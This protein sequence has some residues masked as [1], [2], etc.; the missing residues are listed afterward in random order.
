MKSPKKSSRKKAAAKVGAKHKAKAKTDPLSKVKAKAR[1][2]IAAKAKE[3]NIDLVYWKKRLTKSASGEPPNYDYWLKLEE[4]RER[5]ELW[6]ASCIV[7]GLDPR[8]IHRNVAGMFGVFD[9]PERQELGV[10]KVDWAGA[11][12]WMKLTIEGG[13]FPDNSIRRIIEGVYLKD[14]V[15]YR[16]AN[17]EP[18]PT[19]LHSLY[20]AP[21]KRLTYDQIFKATKALKGSQHE[22]STK[23]NQNLE[24]ILEPY[25]QKVLREHPEDCKNGSGTLNRTKILAVMERECELPPN[26]KLPAYRKRWDDAIK[27]IL[28]RLETD[29][30]LS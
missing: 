3:F 25:V 1:R 21:P 23:G 13:T 14:V 12:F 27:S 28:E 17:R 9:F 15:N 29:D 18:V 26:R 24:S 8:R 22:K 16:F 5:I 4:G 20:E 10:Y 11:F 2:S 6:Q 30:W 19:K 7:C